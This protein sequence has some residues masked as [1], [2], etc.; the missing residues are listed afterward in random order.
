MD[1]ELMKTEA[2][3]GDILFL[4]GTSFSAKVL[5]VFTASNYSHVA[6]LLRGDLGTL[7]VCEMLGGGY[8]CTPAS[9]RIPEMCAQGVVR[10]GRIPI[11]GDGTLLRAN[12]RK[13]M[14]RYRDGSPDTTKDP[15]YSYVGAVLVWL[16]QFAKPLV[17]AKFKWLVPILEK[18][19][20][21][22]IVCSTYA[23][24]MWAAA[25][26]PFDKPAD[27]EDLSRK[28]KALIKVEA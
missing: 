24:A 15:N 11:E 10:F 20:E 27:P 6:L 25:G 1:Y 9:Q 7:W 26:I 3:T 19:A 22:N 13:A 12:V 8:T 14:L 28:V 21:V 16:A 23:Q 18:Y 17:P 2:Q 4:A 5:R